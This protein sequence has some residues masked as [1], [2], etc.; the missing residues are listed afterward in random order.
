M[1]M[2][3][4]ILAGATLLATTQAAPAADRQRGQAL[5]GEC[6]SC[7]SLEGENGVG[8]TLKGVIGRRSGSLSDFRYSPAMRRAGLVWDAATLERFLEDPQA[9]VRGNRM[10]FAGFEE[11]SDRADVA[12]FLAATAL[13]VEAER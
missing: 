6:V 5:F 9:L 10:P 2:R 7:H 3:R 12:A 13:Q 1:K 11:P 4:A 8:P